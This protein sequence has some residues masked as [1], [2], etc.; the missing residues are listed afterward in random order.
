MTRDG[1]GTVRAL[2]DL[3]TT[4][5]TDV[6]RA[7]TVRRGARRP[8]AGSSA[9]SNGNGAT[10]GRLHRHPAGQWAG[11]IGIRVLFNGQCGTGL[12]WIGLREPVECAIPRAHPIEQSPNPITD[13]QTIRCLILVSAEP[14]APTVQAPW[15]VRGSW[16]LVWR[17]S[18]ARRRCAVTP[19]KLSRKSRP[20]TSVPRSLRPSASTTVT[21]QEVNAYLAFDA[22]DMLPAG[23]RPN[24]SMLGA[25]RVT[26]RRSSISIACVSNERRS[27][28]SAT[29]PT[30]TVD[31][32]GQNPAGP[33]RRCE[34]GTR[35]GGHCGIR[36]EALLQQIVSY[37]QV[38]GA[39]IGDQP[40]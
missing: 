7:Q 15:F 40:R 11:E 12:G 31:G 30:G 5:A 22:G 29:L 19:N 4:L 33:G 38:G 16:P 10:K 18:P 13:S 3:E 35:V 14:C 9:F 23:C 8:A 36:S 24:V 6:R 21:E 34:P 17:R 28:R 27:L 32:E 2:N 39:S 20:S 1:Q 25:D 37:S 26:A